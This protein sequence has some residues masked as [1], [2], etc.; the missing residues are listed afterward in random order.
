MLFY[1]LLQTTSN[2]HYTLWEHLYKG[3]TTATKYLAFYLHNSS[4]SFVVFLQILY[5]Y[6]NNLKATQNLT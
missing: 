5:R 3:Q 6:K 1:P 4:D 2:G